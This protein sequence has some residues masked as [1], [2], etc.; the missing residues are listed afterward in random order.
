MNSTEWVL[1]HSELR[2]SKPKTLFNALRNAASRTTHPK[3][4]EAETIHDLVDWMETY[5]GNR[6]I[7]A[8]GA[9]FWEP[10]GKLR[11]NYWHVDKS[12]TPNRRAIDETHIT[13]ELV[14][15]VIDD[16]DRIL[17]SLWGALAQLGAVPAEQK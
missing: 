6:H 11:V 1:R 2:K 16:A 4:I 9:F 15:E 17:R 12:V 10:T 3:A 5:I 7:A 14:S 13:K 8:H